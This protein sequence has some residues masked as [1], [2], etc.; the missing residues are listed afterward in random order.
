MRYPTILVLAGVVVYTAFFFSYSVLKAQVYDSYS[1]DLAN[2]YQVS[3]NVAHGHGF[4]FTYPE[5]ERNVSRLAIHSDYVLMLLAPLTWLWTDWRS[6][7]FVQAAIIALGGW[8]VY[9][10]ARRWLKDDGLAALL[11]GVYFLYGP[12]QF[13]VLWQFHS[14]TLA[15]TFILGMAEAAICRRRPWVY[16]LWF[17]LA[18]ITKEQVG[19]IVGLA[20]AGLWWRS[21]RRLAWWSFSI[22][23]LYSLAHFFFIIPSMRPVTTH[24]VWRFYYGDLGGTPGSAL[25]QLLAPSEILSRLGRFVIGKNAIELLLPLAGLP[26]LSGWILLAGLSVLPAWLTHDFSLTSLYFQNHV[27]AVPFLFLGAA[28]GLA[29]LQRRLRRSWRFW[30]PMVM[31][32]VGFWTIL[33]TFI[34]SPLPWSLVFTRAYVLTDPRLH[35]LE[36]ATAPIPSTAA[37]AYSQGIAAYF[38]NRQNAY[39]LPWGLSRADYIVFFEPRIYFDTFPQEIGRTKEFYAYLRSYLRTSLA[40]ERVYDDDQTLVY[41]RRWA[42]RP[43]P[44]AEKYRRPDRQIQ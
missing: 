17:G 29:W 24:F 25:R 30:R 37:V 22:G 44:L 12:L 11:A 41:R 40:F 3:W 35:T 39:V 26:L 36:R 23:W 27:L 20:G 31:I 9:R 13:P 4:T 6:F 7:L 34:Y 43:A 19:L 32:T 38:R 33:G 16:W 28:G 14:V 42:V 21:N 8:F 18:L 15:V 1:H 10:L 2:M 5:T